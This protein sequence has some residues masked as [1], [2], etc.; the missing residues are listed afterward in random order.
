MRLYMQ[1]YTDIDRYVHVVCVRYAS[2]DSRSLE[3]PQQVYELEK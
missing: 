2:Y 1:D 3:K